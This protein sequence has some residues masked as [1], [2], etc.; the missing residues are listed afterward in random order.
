MLIAQEI[1]RIRS[2][3]DRCGLRPQNAIPSAHRPAIR[4]MMLNGEQDTDRPKATSERYRPAFLGGVRHEACHP[5]ETSRS[6]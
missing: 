5:V 4:F 6:A 3:R 2:P 1:L